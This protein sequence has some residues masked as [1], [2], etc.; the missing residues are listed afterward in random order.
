MESLRDIRQN[1]KSIK[2]IGQVMQTMKMISSARIKNAESA[3]TAARPF[4]LRMEAMIDNLRADIFK[5]GALDNTGLISF[6]KSVINDG[7]KNNVG[8]LLI[9]ADKGLC[10]AFNAMILRAA[11]A[12]IKENKEKNIFVFCIGKKGR[13]F[14]RRLK[15]PN[16]KVVYEAVGIFPK[17]GYVHAD[18]LAKAVMTGFVE[19]NLSKIDLVYNDFKSMASQNIVNTRF[20]PFDF[21]NIQSEREEQD[22]LFEPGVEQTFKMLFPRY[23]SARLYRILLESQAAELAARMNAMDAASKNAQDISSALSL[24]LNKVRQEM[25]TNEILEIVSGANALNA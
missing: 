12:W 21:E 23:L 10:G 8:L 2:S 13:D 14:L 1:I 24:K 6:F 15:M 9:T 7:N 3:M 20:L 4:A 11:L 5:D 22:F 25:I 19:N 17:A 16:I 18:L